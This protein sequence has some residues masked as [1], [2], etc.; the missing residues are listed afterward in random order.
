MKCENVRNTICFASFFHPQ[1]RMKQASAIQHISDSFG[2]THMVIKNNHTLTD[3]INAN[4]NHFLIPPS[5][6][7]FICVDDVNNLAVKII[8]IFT[9][10]KYIYIKQN[11]KNVW[12]FLDLWGCNQ[13]YWMFV[14]LRIKFFFK[15]MYQKKNQT[16]LK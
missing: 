12:K 8:L 5:T 1:L 6:F 4:A 7:P 2:H 10:P 3:P 14:I 16:S 11:M 9:K 15:H 13:I